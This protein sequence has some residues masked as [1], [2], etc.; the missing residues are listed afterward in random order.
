MDYI[1]IPESE[2]DVMQVIWEQM[3]LL[4]GPVPRTVL[5]AE[6]AKVRPMAQTTLLTLVS[7]L[8][9]KG[10]LKS[11]KNGR[12][13]EYVPT[14]SREEYLAKRSRAFIEKNCGGKMSVFASALTSS[15]LSRDEIEELRA[16]LAE[17]KL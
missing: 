7:S 17:D 12:S 9:K 14:I 11:E 16:L 13:S 15:G 8:V 2:L 10:V 6:I 3:D 5:E 1:K 4:D